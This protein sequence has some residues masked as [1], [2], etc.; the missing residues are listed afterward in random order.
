MHTNYNPG[1]RHVS[2]AQAEQSARQ[3]VPPPPPL[4]MSTPA[5]GGMHLPPPPPR[6]PPSA[7]QQQGMMLPPP[8]NSQQGWSQWNRQQSYP[9]PPPPNREPKAYDPS[10]YSAYM[11]MPPLPRD[12]QP[13]VS[14]TYIPGADSWGL[15]VGNP[16]LHSVNSPTNSAGRPPMLPIQN[17]YIRGASGDFSSGLEVHH[18]NVHTQ[19]HPN[20]FQPAGA[21]TSQ[22]P[23][24]SQYQT[25]Q[26]QPQSSLAQAMQQP[27][28][29]PTPS[30][31]QQFFI[32]PAKEKQEYSSPI[33]QTST[34]VKSEAQPI[35]QQREH[36]NSGET[37]AS[38]QELQWPNER[39]LIWLAA[40]GFSNAWQETFK[41]LDIHGA[42]FLD[43]ARSRNVGYLNQTIYPQLAKECTASG[44][45][46]D[47]QREREEGRRIRKLIRRII[48]TGGSTAHGSSASS[49]PMRSHNRRE[50]THLA[51]MSAGTD[52][53]LE[54][55]P[56]LSRSDAVFGSTPT[57][58][59]GGDDSPGRHMP[60]AMNNPGTLAQRR[61]SGQRSV[62]LDTLSNIAKQQDPPETVPRSSYSESILKGLDDIPRRHSPN[63]SADLR[64]TTGDLRASPQQSPGLPSARPAP[65]PSAGQNRYYGHNRASSSEILLSNLGQY[66]SNQP[67]GRMSAG[68]SSNASE[69][70][71]KQPPAEARRNGRE[72]SRP[73]PMDASLRHSSG[74]TPAS[75]KEHRASFLP[76]FMRR[77]KKKDDN[78]PSPDDQDQSPT[79]P[80]ALRHPPYAKSTLNSSETSLDRPASRRSAHLSVELE[81]I[82]PISTRMPGQD[83]HG[84]D[85]KFAL[86][87]PDGWNYRLVDVTDIE[88]AEDLRTEICYNLGVAYTPDVTLHTTTLG[89]ARHEEPLSDAL[90][91]AARNRFADGYANL[92]LFLRAPPHSAAAVHEA[93]G[94]GVNFP[95]YVKRASMARGR[96]MDDTTFS[97]LTG[98]EQIDSPGLRSGESTLVPDKVKGIQNLDKDGLS[99][100]AVNSRLKSENPPRDFNT[101]PEAE[102][103]AILEARAEEHRKEIKRKQEAYMTQ[104]QQMRKESSAERR[105]VDFDQPR[106]SPYI[107]N[108]RP[109]SFVEDKKTD[110]TLVP[111]RKPP[112]VPEPTTTLAKANSK[113]KKTGPG[114]TSWPD[115]KEDSWK[116][117]SDEPIPE[118][119]EMPK[120]K[121]LPHSPSIAS[122][123]G[124]ALVGAGKITGAIGA[125]TTPRPPSAT[126]RMSP[127]PKRALA[128]VNFANGR[129]SPGNGGSPR[130]PFTMSKGN[131]P[132]KIPDYVE[133]NGDIPRDISLPAH[134]RPQLSLSMPTPPASS[135]DEKKEQSRP[136]S[137]DVS[138]STYHPPPSLSRMSSRR[139][140]IGNGPSFD[141]PD[142]P[143]AFSNSPSLPPQEEDEDSDDGLFAIPLAKQKAKAAPTPSSGESKIK[144]GS[145]NKP[146]LS[147]KTSRQN[148]KVDSAKA[149]SSDH[150]SAADPSTADSTMPMSAASTGWSA[151]SPD[152]SSR[153]GRRES[154]A[155]DVWA[156]R[157]PAEALVEHL[158]EFFPNVD[159]DQPMVDEEQGPSGGDSPVSSIGRSTLGTQAS[160]V[161]L[162]SRSETPVS[163]A[164]EADTLGSDQSTLKAG[165]DSLQNVAQR[166]MRKSGALGRTKSI[167]EVVKGAYQMPNQPNMS[168]SSYGSGRVSSVGLQGPLVNRVS[169]LKGDIVRRKSTKMFGAKIEQ[170]KPPRGSR[171]IQLETIPQDTLPTS[172][173]HH[174][175]QP[176]RQPTFK[177]MK[178]QLIGKGTFGRVYLGMNTTTG[179]LLA[180]KQVEVNPKAAGADPAKIREM[181]K[182]L[183]QEIDTMQHLDHVNIVQ[184]LGC[185]RKEY[186]ISIFLEYISGGSVGSCLR[187]HGKFEESVVSSL[188]RQTLCGLAYLHREGILHRD[189]KADNILLDLDGTCKISDFGI[190]KRSRNPYN[191]D[192]TN[193]MQGSVFWMAPEVI[194][195]Q[196]QALTTNGNET[197]DAAMN[198]GYS[199]KVDIW[200]LGCVVLEMFAGRRPWSKEEAIGAIYKLGSLN[201]APPI[202]DDVSNVVGPAALSFI[203]P[204]DRPTA[205]TLLRAPFCFSDPNYNFLDTELY[206]KIR[207]AF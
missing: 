183:D 29:P 138:P 126:Q 114:R 63:A 1:Q 171:L 153:F 204:A 140:Y 5:P 143:V 108:D 45:G 106:H 51:Q 56:N 118:T 187:K 121:A 124:A 133:E 25:Q 149:T 19:G 17:S 123:I 80:A 206:A 178:G 2:A 48:E 107:D 81:K 4:S 16:P 99:L 151:D 98:N 92:K 193:S 52:G 60:L 147:L 68:L 176:Q 71:Y 132:F 77:G 72:G 14:A 36:S 164:D 35:P 100:D 24:Y 199:A 192:I 196:S 88:S 49:L 179:E 103:L 145:P 85:R 62:T 113:S 146:A 21:E 54:S 86:V 163:S 166:N 39:V 66:D 134:G 89:Q 22:W 75:A 189:L 177:W 6:P 195:A 42:Q 46:W 127:Q 141:I 120:R 175:M 73:P 203:D 154:F 23:T 55:S 38:P 93:T 122:G 160:S 202:P 156:N 30:S 194:R 197:G 119:C 34:M 172:S 53:T 150:R 3:Y 139:S 74:E 181:V 180:V 64:P 12:D 137:P 91:V 84:L 20:E 188:T 142:N 32:Q 61:F 125:P 198:Q 186:S 96:P 109:R 8:P 18:R 159:L 97:R 136:R 161:D 168:T 41:T 70:S 87:T 26:Q 104:R 135:R 28:A 94:L 79:S 101:L 200:S 165:R 67:S 173:V 184:Y 37:P 31:R 182:A 117:L 65:T 144:P 201:Q 169:T 95:S 205:E 83:R 40:E 9:P 128:E 44:V 110:P 76:N 105:V 59:G 157:P 167:R 43:L 15:G 47:Q 78:H 90:L 129:N 7:T 112:P 158:D 162:R 115:K 58:A 174:Q 13:L 152:G 190:S 50:S 185:E 130:S 207:G 191:N 27:N 69:S 116:R 155:S 170:I 82:P 33:T 11:N 111:L 148:F 131:V 102:R 10:D 57:T